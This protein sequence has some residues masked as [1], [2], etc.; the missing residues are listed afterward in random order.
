ML[1]QGLVI[2]GWLPSV[3]GNAWVGSVAVGY[4]DERRRFT[5]AGHVGTGFSDAA[6]AAL[7]KRLEAIALPGPNPVENL[8]RSSAKGLR[9]VKPELVSEIEYRAWRR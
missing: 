2:F 9:Y 4:Y 7:A 3:N 6:S 8:T 1:R 5:Y